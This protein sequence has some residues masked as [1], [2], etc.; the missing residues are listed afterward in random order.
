[1]IDLNKIY[2]LTASINKL[3]TDG[4]LDKND[5]VDGLTIEVTVPPQTHYGIDKEFYRQSNNDS[6]KGFEHTNEPIIAVV[7][8]V[9]LVIVAASGDEDAKVDK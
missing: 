6:L 9:N 5:V 8:D 4:V 7:D 2:S 3:V 1:M